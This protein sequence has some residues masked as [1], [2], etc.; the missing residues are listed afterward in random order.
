VLVHRSSVLVTFEGQGHR[1]EFTVTGWKS[2]RCD[3]E[4]RLASYW[5]LYH[6]VA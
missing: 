6:I 3:L 5:C 1:S 2:G 4:W